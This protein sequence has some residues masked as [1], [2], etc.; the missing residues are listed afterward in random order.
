M[1]ILISIAIVIAAAVLIHRL[2]A[3]RRMRARHR[4]LVDGVELELAV[5]QACTGRRAPP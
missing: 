3:R 4:Q 2:L 1:T 5:C